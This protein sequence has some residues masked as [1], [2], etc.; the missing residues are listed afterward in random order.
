MTEH[1]I[2]THRKK[3]DSPLSTG[4]GGSVLQLSRLAVCS[5]AAIRGLEVGLVRIGGCR[6]GRC[7]EGCAGGGRLKSGSRGW[8]C[9]CL[10][11][12]RG[13]S[14]A[15]QESKQKRDETELE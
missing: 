3:F 12:D 14:N 2:A 15:Q 9:H 1:G 4:S 10:A 11:R 13:K 5:L 6:N 7:A 8:R